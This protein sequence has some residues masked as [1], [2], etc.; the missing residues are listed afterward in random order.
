MYITKKSNNKSLLLLNRKTKKLEVYELT[1]EKYMRSVIQL[2][3]DFSPT[4]YS[5]YQKKFEMECLF[6][7]DDSPTPHG[8][9]DIIY[10]SKR[11]EEY[12]SGYYP[13]YNKVKFYGYLT[14]F[15]DYFIHSDLYAGEAT[16]NTY[17]NLEPISTD[18]DGTSGCIRVSQEDLNWLL[19]NVDIGT[20]VV[21]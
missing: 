18:D 8:L 11:D 13:G 3:E 7:H 1:D 15:E 2:R 19:E 9:V 17:M 6:G 4:K 14:I 16:T 10:K 5:V 12:I 21:L 20:T